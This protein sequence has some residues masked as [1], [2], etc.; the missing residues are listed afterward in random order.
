MTTDF[1]NRNNTNAQ[2]SKMLRT[3]I[4]DL[5]TQNKNLETANAELSK[6]IK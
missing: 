1:K 3:K 4:A 2:N 6:K 5:D